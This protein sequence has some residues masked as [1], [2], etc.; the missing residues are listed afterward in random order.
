MNSE[1]NM[2][3]GNFNPVEK[4]YRS[5]E[6]FR[7]EYPKV[8]IRDAAKQLGVTEAQLVAV[9][10]GE[11]STR[12]DNRFEAI[13]KQLEGFGELLAITRNDAVVHE[14]RG[15]YDSMRKHGN[16]GMY[17]KPGMDTRFFFDE[18]DSVFAVN[19]N[20]RLS[21]QFFDR[22][23][24]SAH[25]VYLTENSHQSQYFDLVEAF[26]SGNQAIHQS[27]KARPE[28]IP[29]TDLDAEALRTAWEGIRDVHEGSRIIHSLGR[30][31]HQ[32]V[33]RALGED[34]ARP[35]QPSMV[36]KL[37]ETFAEKQLQLMIFVMGKSAVQSYGGQIHKILRTGPWFNV[38]DKPFNL[39]L[40]S[41]LLDRVWLLRKPSDDGW[42]TSLDVFDHHSQEVMVICDN[43]VRGQNES[44]QWTETVAELATGFQVGVH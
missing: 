34:Y 25:K 38:L 44:Q 18:W 15:V 2:Q 16:V 14:T 28:K 20:E 19:E 40:K 9:R 8:R 23:G 30:G 3:S 29:A 6:Q 37:I 36:E 41:E 1:I 43:R 13:F 22:Y 12:L 31:D 24:Q 35:L 11:T 21:I 42:I 10:C 33:Y 7:S 26:R 4:L 17:F 39:H 27:V 5:W 32:A